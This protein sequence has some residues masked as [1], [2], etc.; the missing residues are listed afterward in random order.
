MRRR[1]RMTSDA[2]RAVHQMLVEIDDVIYRDARTRG[3]E[4]KD[5]KYTPDEVKLTEIIDE[6]QGQTTAML[7]AIS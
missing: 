1:N 5:F 4:N 2:L 3:G 6:A 7:E